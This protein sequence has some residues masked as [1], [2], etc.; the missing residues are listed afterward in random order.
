MLASHNPDV[1]QTVRRVGELMYQSHEGYSAIG[2]G[3]PETDAMIDGLRSLGPQE[4]FY[5]GRVSGGG[6]GGAVVVLVHEQ[7]LPRMRRLAAR[8]GRPDRFIRAAVAA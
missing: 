2:L 6:S 8:L 7:A 4:G 3:C 5:G 1:E